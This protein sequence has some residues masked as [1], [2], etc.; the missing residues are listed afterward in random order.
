M[1]TNYNAILSRKTLILLKNMILDTCRPG[2]VCM[3]VSERLVAASDHH[4]GRPGREILA[5]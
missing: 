4:A 5:G 1:K 3:I 2:E